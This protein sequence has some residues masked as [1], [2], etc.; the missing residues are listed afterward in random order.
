MQTEHPSGRREGR[1]RLGVAIVTMGT[2]P[3]EVD[4]LL[5]SVADQ[6]EPADR[7]VIVGNGTQNTDV[8]PDYTGYGLPD[9]VTVL[10][11]AENLGCPGGRNEALAAL[12]RAGDIDVVV[13]LD[14]DGL[15]VDKDTFTWVR[16]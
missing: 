6:T 10:E 8:L 11:T 12:R 14:D 2:R 13:E 15:L 4:A 3:A 1:P 16:D 7:I 9:R 5:A